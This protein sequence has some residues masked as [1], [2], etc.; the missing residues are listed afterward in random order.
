MSYRDRSEKIWS[1]INGNIKS[2]IRK[3]SDLTGISK[4]SVHR[5]QQGLKNRLLYPESEFWESN[6]GQAWLAR[7]VCAVLFTFVLKRGIGLETVE[8]FFKQLRLET[9]LGISAT[10]LREVRNRIEEL[11]NQ[12]GEEMEKRGLAASPN[13]E[14]VGAADETFFDKMILVFL[15]LPSNYLLLEEMSDKRDALTWNE[16]VNK[17]LKSMNVRVRYLVS[18]RAKALIKLATQHLGCQSIADLF[19]TMHELVKG[20]SICINTKFRA[21]ITEFEKADEQFKKVKNKVKDMRTIAYRRPLKRL[22]RAI[23]AVDTWANVQFIYQENLRLFSLCVHPFDFD[24][25]TVQTTKQ[26]ENRLLEITNNLETLVKENKL[27][28]RNKYLSKVK[29]QSVE[30]AVA[31]DIWWIWVEQTLS[32]HPLSELQK[33]WLKEF[34]LPVVYWEQQIKKT[35]SRDLRIRLKNSLHIATQRLKIHPLTKQLTPEANIY[36]TKW[37]KRMSLRYQRTSSAVEGRN[38]YLSRINNNSRGISKKRLKVMTVLHNFDTRNDEGTTPGQRFFNI[39][40][41]DLFETILVHIGEMPR[42]RK[43]R[44]GSNSNTLITQPVPA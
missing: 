40:F 31:L 38:G 34:L 37:A 43:R 18:D 44:N 7:L 13:Q 10:A 6:A 17:A 36:W 33:Q 25:L 32:E 27:P 21:A 29:K 8:V 19:H 28:D 23:S 39:D 4:S 3:I 1:H 26:L 2:T 9:H 24:S 35:R 16:K 12:Y 30:I 5:H 14:I 20:F 15:D 42:P 22:E 11:I 41:P